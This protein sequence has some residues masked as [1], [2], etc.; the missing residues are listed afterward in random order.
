MDRIFRRD[1]PRYGPQAQGILPGAPPSGGVGP[2]P[3]VSRGRS[4][5]IDPDPGIPSGNR[6]LREG[7]AAWRVED[8]DGPVHGAG[9][10]RQVDEAGARG[11]S[12][13]RHRCV[14]GPRGGELAPRPGGR[15]RDARVVVTPGT[16]AG[17]RGSGHRTRTVRPGGVHPAVRVPVQQERGEPR[18]VGP[19]RDQV[20]A[21]SPCAWEREQDPRR[22]HQECPDGA[23]SPAS[24]R[25]QSC[26]TRSDGGKI[27]HWLVT[28]IR[29]TNRPASG[30]GLP[31]NRRTIPEF[32]IPDQRFPEPS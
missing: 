2:R 6:S 22:E 16:L 12:R 26:Q 25:S 21:I 24:C 18:P 19:R 28:G 32:S 7:E 14:P 29:S 1:W 23:E 8:G 30:R 11:R 9:T 27:L 5:G 20:R 3:R 13:V 15:R 17:A 31:C 4:S 10:G